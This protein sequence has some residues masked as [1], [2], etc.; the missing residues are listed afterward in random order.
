[1]ASAGH[2]KGSAPSVTGKVTAVNGDPTLGVCGSA[3]GTG[4]FTLN[5]GG[6]TPTVHTVDVT[7]ATSF[8]QRKI[9]GPTF[10]NVCNGDDA[11]VIGP[12]SS[13]VLSASA[14][15]I[16]VPNPAHHLGT[17]TSVGGVSTSGTCGTANASG[18]FTLVTVV[19]GIPVVTTAFV[20]SDTTFNVVHV[21]TSTFASVCVGD[22]ADADGLTVGNTVLAATVK[23]RI[24]KP[25]APLHVKGTVSSVG[26]V[27]TPGTCG[28]A[29]TDG[30]F[31]ITWNHPAN[32]V[33]NTTVNVTATTPFSGKTGVTSFADVCVGARSSV[34]GT[35]LSG[36]LE[37]LAVA[38]Y[39][40]KA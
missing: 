26:G 33:I 9:T 28:V 31:V 20:T 6:A 1:V 32:T 22:Y 35:Y 39:P 18:D 34:I 5:T 38:T 21:G 30:N 37:A 17:V 16:H 25:P 11:T 19:S 13:S 27:T 24:P 4:S 23:I 8:V 29:D 40:V 36:A 2:T 3:G 15:S 14:V 12:E 7:P 10:A